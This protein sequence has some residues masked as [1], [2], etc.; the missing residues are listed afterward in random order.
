MLCCGVEPR[1]LTCMDISAGVQP[2]ASYAL[3]K[4]FCRGSGS[5]PE[6]STLCR[7]FCA[8]RLKLDRRLG[9]G[10]RAS[11]GLISATASAASGQVGVWT[12]LLAGLLPCTGAQG[13][14]FHMHAG[15]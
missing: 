2:G 3:Y 1:L 6:K 5:K 15:R 4:L 14:Q 10:A 8:L 12:T 13:F 11:V 9:A 7:G